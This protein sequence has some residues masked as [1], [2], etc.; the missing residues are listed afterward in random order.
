MAQAQLVLEELQ[1]QGLTDV[2]SLP[3]NSSAAL[4]SLLRESADIRLH[5]VTREG[6]AFAL[7]AGLWI[8][9]RHPLVLIQNT[10]LL[11]SGDSLRGTLLRMRLPVVCLVTYRGYAKLARLG[12][13]PANL[14]AEILSRADLDSVALMTE[15][16]LR[17]WGIPFDFFHTDDDLP[18]ISAAFAKARDLS[19]PVAVLV[20]Q[21]MS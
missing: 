12:G 19:S 2:V 3:D 10:G 7:A 9:G 13:A 8:G 17:A 18:K 6:E 14:N 11:E 16:T 21:D 1:R 4:L 20:T 15:P 5:S